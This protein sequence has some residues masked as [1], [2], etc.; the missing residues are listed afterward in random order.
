MRLTERVALAGIVG[1]LTACPPNLSDT[2]SLVTVPTVIAIQ[3]TPAEAPPM[4]PVTYT[5]LVVSSADAGAPRLAWDYCNARNPLT[6]LGPINT[7]CARSGSPVLLSLGG[8]L[9]V[10]GAI[11]GTACSNFGPDAPP[12]VDGGAGSQ[13]VDPDSTGGY[14]QP[15]TAFLDGARADATLYLMRLSCGFSGASEASQGALS[16]RYHLNTNPAVASLTSGAVTL[17]TQE[18]GAANR[19]AR[20]AKLDLVA[21]WETCPLVDRCGDGVCGAD[22]SVM[23]CPADCTTPRGCTGAERYVNLDV[24]SQTVVD[25]REGIHVSWY[26]TAGTFDQDRTGN[27][28]TNSATTSDNGWTPPSKPGSVT[29]W[30]VFHDDRGGIGWA[31]YAL[32]VN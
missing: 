6:N 24:T 9:D 7:A 14:Y 21:G 12:A 19:V 10:S 29:L 11:P 3:S 8:G 18:T 16:A 13:A 27:D 32:D 25:Q 28:G 2:T 22:E 31:T 30:V 26:A 5:A 1:T 17:V 4:T 20:G 15:V 23:T